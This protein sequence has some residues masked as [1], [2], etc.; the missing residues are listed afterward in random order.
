MSQR[1]QAASALLQRS[2]LVRRRPVQSLICNWSHKVCAPSTYK[3]PLHS[4]QAAAK[5]AF[6]MMNSNLLPLAGMHRSH[7]LPGAVFKLAQL[8]QLQGCCGARER[9]DPHQGLVIRNAQRAQSG[10]GTCIRLQGLKQQQQLPQCS[11]LSQQSLTHL[12][13]LLTLACCQAARSLQQHQHQ[14][15]LSCSP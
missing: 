15:A 6:L 13:P 9:A 11:L 1:R 8:S 10:S 4:C 7:V 14:S 5:L 3:L 12:Q 2:S